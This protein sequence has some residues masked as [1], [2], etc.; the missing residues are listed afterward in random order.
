[1]AATAIKGADAVTI[2]SFSV[3]DDANNGLSGRQISQWTSNATTFED[4][5]V[6]IDA[7][8]AAPGGIGLQGSI[9][10]NSRLV[11]KR[12][13]PAGGGSTDIF[14]VE[15][16]WGSLSS[17][18]EPSPPTFESS[19]SNQWVYS[20]STTTSQVQTNRDAAGDE[21]IVG[22][23]ESDDKEVDGNDEVTGIP[24]SKV[25]VNKVVP[26][27]TVTARGTLTSN[28]F[29]GVS[30]LVGKLND[31]TVTVN[32]P[33]GSVSFAA[34]TLMLA[35]LSIT[36]PANGRA[37]N[38][39]YTFEYRSDPDDWKAVVVATDPKTGKPYRGL[40]AIP[41]DKEATP[42]APYGYVAYEIYEK[43]SFGALA[44]D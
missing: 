13:T 21:I 44:V 3:T 24:K 8:T 11:S 14:N 36:S 42:A 4:K 22:T 25:M 40:P 28:P 32:P 26:S 7:A 43:V 23:L 30:D 34:G 5:I 16:V 2:S 41:V 19:G 18:G 31:S 38:V 27:T 10:Q 33:G 15:F 6:E 39:S 37:W 35:G 9:F 29:A 17:K 12:I 20:F 1:M